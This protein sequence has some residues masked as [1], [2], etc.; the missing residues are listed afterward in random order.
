MPAPPPLSE[1]CARHGIADES[2]A[3]NMIIT[4]KRRF[5]AVL[6]QRVRPFVDSETEV[7]AEIRDLMSTLSRGADGA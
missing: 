5:R 3:S 2:T 7:E 4:V 1:L 6:H